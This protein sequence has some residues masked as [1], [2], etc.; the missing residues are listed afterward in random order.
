MGYT[1]IDP[2]YKPHPNSRLDFRC[3]RPYVV[4]VRRNIVV[5][6][7][8]KESSMKREYVI[9]DFLAAV[10]ADALLAGRPTLRADGPAAQ[11]RERRPISLRWL[12]RWMGRLARR[13]TKARSMPVQLSF[14]DEWG[15]S[16]YARQRLAA[17]LGR[18]GSA[19]WYAAEDHGSTAK[20]AIP[21]DKNS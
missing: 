18:S 5:A 13:A 12:K 19:G 4:V 14:D 17:T 11:P 15:D 1:P 10:T 7:C 9:P 3:G 16:W 20:S 6:P 2:G 21:A 8:S